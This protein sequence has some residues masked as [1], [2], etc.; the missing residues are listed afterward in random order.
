VR[1]WRIILRFD[2]LLSLLLLIATLVFWVRA[3]WRNGH[4]DWQTA[5]TW[6]SVDVEAEGL[7]YGVIHYSSP[8]RPVQSFGIEEPELELKNV[9]QTLR[10]PLNYPEQFSLPGFKY[11]WGLPSSGW[12]V[13]G[14]KWIPEVL[15]DCESSSQ[16]TVRWWLIAALPPVVWVWRRR[17]VRGVDRGLCATFGYDLCATP[18]RCPEC[19][20]V[21]FVSSAG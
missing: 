7:R 5:R 15:A 1:V 13:I 18:Q 2:T 11:E 21:S 8:L 16:I 12:L 9:T 6:R 14:G 10:I 4:I 19:G 20:S 17:R 3:R